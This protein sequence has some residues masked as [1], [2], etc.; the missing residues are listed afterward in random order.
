M[1]RRVF[2]RRVVYVMFAA[3]FLL[4]TPMTG[5][6]H[7]RSLAQRSLL[8]A[9]SGASSGSSK[10]TTHFGFQEV[11][12]DTKEDLVRSVFS[13]V[14]GKYDLMND[15]MSLGVHRLWKD[16]FVSTLNPGRKGPLRCLDVAG[17]TG[18]IALR[19]LDHAREKHYDRETTVEVL[20]INPDMLAEGR[21]RFKLTMYH[22]TP[23]ISFREGNAQKLDLP[24]NTYD[25]YT[26]AFGIRNC[27]SIPDVL[28]EAHRVLKPGGTFACLEFSHVTNPLL[29]SVYD[30]YSFSILPLLGS[31]LASDRASYQYLVESIRR[32]PPQEEFGQM[33]RDAG[34]ATGDDFEGK[35]GAWTDLWGGIASI[36]KGVKL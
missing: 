23:Q 20:D 17:G 26:I 16:T 30:Q 6:R 35:G 11:E 12:T 1:T 19:I 8:N 34:F 7:L 21:K 5:A 9:R 28:K 4:E 2:W 3:L 25:L 10:S 14:A 27:T 31:I 18:D 22:N 24:S 15:A 13:S 32:F 29:S 36:H 33:I